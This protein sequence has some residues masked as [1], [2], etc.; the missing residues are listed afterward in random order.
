MAR[1][2]LRVRAYTRVLYVVNG[3]GSGKLVAQ[4][5]G[6]V[7]VFSRS[8]N[9][10]AVQEKTAEAVLALADVERRAVTFEDYRNET[11]ID[12]SPP[13]RPDHG[14]SGDDQPHGLDFGDAS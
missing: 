8:L 7:P 11:L 10:Y 12:L 6:R 1:P 13:S 9:G 4:V 5:T 3:P 2:W 14:L